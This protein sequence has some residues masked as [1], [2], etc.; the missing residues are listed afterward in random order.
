[1]AHASLLE[2]KSQLETI[3]CRDKSIQSKELLDQYDQLGAKLYS[4]IKY[5]E[6]NWNNYN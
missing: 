3:A 5:V 1:M 6:R 4:F 2:C